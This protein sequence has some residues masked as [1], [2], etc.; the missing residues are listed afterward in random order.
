[1]GLAAGTTL[2]DVGS[3][4]FWNMTLLISRRSGV[5]AVVVE[6]A[7]GDQPHPV[8]SAAGVR[9]VRVREEQ[10]RAVRRVHNHGA[11]ARDPWV[12]DDRTSN[13]KT[14]L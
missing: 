4:V 2:L 7:T 13:S 10:H 3:V 1:M 14:K 6:R 12:S 5:M 8:R 11:Q 9:T